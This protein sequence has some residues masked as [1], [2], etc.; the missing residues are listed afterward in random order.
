MEDEVTNQVEE[1]QDNSE[2]LDKG[3]TQAQVDKIV[4]ERL[5]RQK[6]EHDRLLAQMQEEMESKSSLLTTY[7]EQLN[8]MIQSQ[9]GDVPEAMKEL[10]DKLSIT[11]KLEYL[12]K[13]GQELRGYERQPIPPTPKGSDGDKSFKPNTKGIFKI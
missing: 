10:F 7:E 11:E 1:I 2:N 6:K 8:A 12:S 3:F 4:R 5:Q 9:L 13:F